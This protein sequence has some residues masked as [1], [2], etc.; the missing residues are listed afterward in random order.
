MDDEISVRW[1]E[2]S[3]I[4]FRNQMRRNLLLSG[5]GKQLEGN[6][7]DTTHWNLAE[8]RGHRNSHAAVGTVGT[9]SMGNKLWGPQDRAAVLRPRWAQPGSGEHPW[10][11]AGGEEA[12]ML[13]HPALQGPLGAHQLENSVNASQTLGTPNLYCFRQVTKSTTTAPL[14]YK[15]CHCNMF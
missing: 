5:T 12:A 14:K 4:T 1:L 11:G 7:Q 13:C 9:V 10:H 15:D 6:S 8:T 2:E 3:E